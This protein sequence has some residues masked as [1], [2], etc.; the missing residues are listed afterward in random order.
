MGLVVPDDWDAGLPPYELTDDPSSTA[1]SSPYDYGLRVRDATLEVVVPVIPAGIVLGRGDGCDVVLR[2]PSVSRQ[3]IR[4]EPKGDAVV[5]T[6]LGS[7][8]HARLEGAEVVDSV[9]MRV[10]STLDVCG[11]LLTLVRW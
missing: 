11:V 3:H 10:G 4:I 5:V 2:A 9:L 8:N 7:T 1:Y 6:D